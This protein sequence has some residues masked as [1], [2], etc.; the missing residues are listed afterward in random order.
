[1]RSMAACHVNVPCPPDWSSCSEADCGCFAPECLSVLLSGQLGLVV[2]LLFA[3]L[4]L[5]PSVLIVFCCCKVKTSPY[6]KWMSQREKNLKECRYV[7]RPLLEGPALAFR[8]TGGRGWGC[9]LI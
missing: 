9:Q 4:V 7:E 5:V 2:G 3:F 6:H 1:M 8:V